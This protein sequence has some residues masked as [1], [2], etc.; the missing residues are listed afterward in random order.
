[1]IGR[2]Y[3]PRWDCGPVDSVWRRKIIPLTGLTARYDLKLTLSLDRTRIDAN[4]AN[5]D[6]SGLSISLFTMYFYQMEYTLV[7]RTMEKRDTARS[8]KSLRGVLPKAI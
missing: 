2:L 6:G 3:A 5:R 4:R 1:M 8:R 7:L